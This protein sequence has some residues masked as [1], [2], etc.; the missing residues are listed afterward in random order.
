MSKDR[1]LG[2]QL[3]PFAVARIRSREN[4]LLSDQDLKNLMGCQTYSECIQYLLDRGWGPTANNTPEEL[5]SLEKDRLQ[6]LTESLL[7]AEESKYLDV[8]RI[9]DDYHNLKAAIKESYIQ[10]E[11]PGIYMDGGVL[12]ADL[13]RRCAADGEF[14]ALPSEMAHA[15]EKA[16]DILFRT[17]DSQLC[18]VIIDRECL[19]SLKRSARSTGN[20]L[21]AEYAQ[22]RCAAAN[23]NIAVRAVRAG[24]DEEFL[25]EALVECDTVSPSRLIL[26]SRN[27]LDEVYEYLEQTVYKDAVDAIKESPAAFDR[28]CDNRMM[29]LIR[30]Q[31]YNAF[32]ISPIAAFVLAKNCEIKSV[33]LILS[34][35]RNHLPDEKIRERLR[36]SYV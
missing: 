20:E 25:K 35:K 2:E 14:G 9:T 23:I 27:G 30:P 15:A 18:D 32:T 7:K 33:R 8:F 34:G 29:Q 16:R 6:E 28:W 19:E 22:L 4:T 13:I 24:K 11:V 1:F 21:L 5:I 12:D 17:G 36:E 10:K 26:A 3:M 31:K